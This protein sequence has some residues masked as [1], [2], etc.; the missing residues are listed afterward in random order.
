LTLLRDNSESHDEDIEDTLSYLMSD[1]EDVNHLRR[2]VIQQQKQ[3]AT[4]GQ[5]VNWVWIAE[6][7]GPGLDAGAC[8]TQWQSLPDECKVGGVVS[9]KHWDHANVNPV[10]QGI[11]T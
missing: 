8:I 5:S 10:K 9:S 1:R 4:S 6:H 2:P 3:E 7:I 11:I